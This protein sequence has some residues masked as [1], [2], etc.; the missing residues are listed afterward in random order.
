ML[1]ARYG[2]H[3]KNCLRQTK[4]MRRMSSYYTAPCPKDTCTFQRRVSTRRN[5]SYAT[6]RRSLSDTSTSPKELQYMKILSRFDTKRPRHSR[7]GKPLAL[8]TLAALCMTLSCARLPPNQNNL[9]GR[10]IHVMM[11]FADTMQSSYYY[12]FL[13]NKYGPNGTQHANGPVPVLRPSANLNG[14]FGNGFATGS[15]PTAAGTISGL[16]DYGI[17]DYVLF[18]SPQD[19][20]IGL[21]HFYGNPNLTPTGTNTGKP[22]NV[23]LPA[24]SPNSA[25]AA[26]TLSFDIDMAQLFPDLTSQ[27]AQAQA[28]RQVHYLQVNI[29]A[30]DKT[31]TDQ[32]PNIIKQ[33]DSFGDSRDPNQLASGYLTII[34]D[35]ANSYDSTQNYS[36]SLS[37]E[38]SNDDV[39][40][41]PNPNLD[42]RSWSITVQPSS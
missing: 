26:T 3:W 29:V 27:T 30:T 9:S 4:M 24:D 16:P 38:P 28:G 2:L 5:P 22:F 13:I 12:Y 42:L 17:T 15:S 23:I 37:P 34:L 8:G 1:R 32:N 41:G 20:N 21:Y 36:L 25:T 33:V 7:L 10:R 19:Q 39:Y 40:N 6:T 18:H 11:Q 14:G 31:P 35:T